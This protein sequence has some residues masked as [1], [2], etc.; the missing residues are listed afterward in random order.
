MV[1]LSSP[2]GRTRPVEED[3]PIERPVSKRPSDGLG[4]I[5]LTTVTPPAPR[6]REDTPA[7]ATSTTTPWYP[8]DELA[9]TRGGFGAA[10]D[11]PERAMVTNRHPDTKPASFAAQPSLSAE[12]QPPMSNVAISFGERFA[13]GALHAAMPVTRPVRRSWSGCR[14]VRWDPKKDEQYEVDGGRFHQVTDPAPCSR[15]VSYEAAGFVKQPSMTSR[16]VSVSSG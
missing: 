13:V 5:E 10:L 9:D 2:W 4:E 6:V 15:F 7:P 1:S 14:P 16:S 11:G 8:P 3:N 12:R